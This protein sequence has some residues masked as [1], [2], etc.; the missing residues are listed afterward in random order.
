MSLF[1]LGSWFQRWATLIP[2]DV[3]ITGYDEKV[4]RIP[5]EEVANKRICNISRMKKSQIKQTLRFRHSDWNKITPFCNDVKEEIS[6]ECSELITDGSRPFRATLREINQDHLAF[7]IDTRFNIRPGS[8]EFFDNQ[9]KV[10][11]IICRS[12]FQE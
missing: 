2:N 6:K 7:V 10:L 12:L 5:N 1:F 4:T 9:D 8:S 11:Q 3:H